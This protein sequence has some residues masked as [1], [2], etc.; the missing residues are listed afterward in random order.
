MTA[1][2]PFKIAILPALVFCCV[3]CGQPTL[4]PHELSDQ[5]LTQRARELSQEFLIVDTHV[6]IPYRLENGMEDISQ[7]TPGGDFDYPR[8]REG[9]LDAP[10]MSIYVSASYQDSGGAKEKADES[11]DMVEGFVEKWPDKFALASDVA[12]VRRNFENGLISLPLGMENGAPIEDS[13]QNLRHFFE[14]GIRYI[15]LTHSRANQIC[16]SSYDENRKWNGLSPFGQEVVA[17]MNRL[18]IMIDISHVSDETFFQV[19]QLTRA[20]VI[21]S[22]SSCRHFTPGWERNM[23]D[24]MIRRLAENGGVIQIAWGSSFIS[25]SFREED[26]RRGQAIEEYLREHGLSRESEQGRRYI[27]DYERSNP[28]QFADIAEV[29]DHIDH[30]V[31]LVGP[32]HVGF[33]S[34]F[35]GVGDTLPTG[36]KDVSQYPNLIYHMLKRGYSEEEIEKICGGNLL[37]VWEAVERV[38]AL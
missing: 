12:S 36:L 28:I 33:G 2:S 8:A 29:V 19:L 20:P 11:I 7:R 16:D 30:V 17:E 35:E 23:S 38:A 18:G 9:G 15:T 26:R 1:S 14:R 22:H 24:E 10:F 37:R 6:D 13:L 32:D 31:G 4:P 5:D 21:A 3:G 34:D 25:K 27:L